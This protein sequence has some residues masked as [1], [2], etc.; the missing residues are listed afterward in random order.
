[1]SAPIARQIADAGMTRSWAPW[2]LD[3]EPGG[4]GELQ[5][6]HWEDVPE[7][8]IDEA[9]GAGVSRSRITSAALRAAREAAEDAGATC[10]P[11]GWYCAED[12]DQILQRAVYGRTVWG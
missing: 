8:D 3:I 12:A 2:W 11:R 5:V 6:T 10:C 1:M 4:R 7:R 9:T